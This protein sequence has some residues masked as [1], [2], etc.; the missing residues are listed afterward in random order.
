[1]RTCEPRDGVIEVAV[2]LGYGI[3]TWAM[4][5][6][7]ERPADVWLCKLIQVV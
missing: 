7:M 5:I 4:A 3:H 6:R 2:V 1:M